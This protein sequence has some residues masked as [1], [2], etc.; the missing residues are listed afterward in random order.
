MMNKKHYSD[1]IRKYKALCV[2][3]VRKC[4]LS[5]IQRADDSSLIVNTDN[6]QLIYLFND[7]IWGDT[8]ELLKLLFVHKYLQLAR[9]PMSWTVDK[10]T[11]E[12]LG[13]DE[14][15]IENHALEIDR[16]L[17]VLENLCHYIVL[18]FSV[19]YSTKCESWLCLLQLL[20]ISAVNCPALEHAHSHGTV[21]TNAT[22]ALIHRLE[23]ACQDVDILWAAAVC[24]M[25]LEMEQHQRDPMS[26]ER[27]EHILGEKL[28]GRFA[29]L[30]NASADRLKTICESVSAIARSRSCN[31][32]ADRSHNFNSTDSFRQQFSIYLLEDPSNVSWN[33]A[34][35]LLLQSFDH[36]YS[37]EEEF[38]DKRRFL[39]QCVSWQRAKTALVGNMSAMETVIKEAWTSYRS[40]S[41]GL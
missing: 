13:S 36:L 10:L 21:Y 41:E 8:N 11:L 9:T 29:F 19:P 40:S 16:Q 33:K 6:D 14:D 18:I 34:Q 24:P 39:L 37:R 25:P 5:Q 15:D 22:L 26:Y 7:F 30:Q 17:R 32:H 27:V 35:H 2:V 28:R 4:R 20:L 12:L 23:S 31:Y 38:A 3:V 1:V